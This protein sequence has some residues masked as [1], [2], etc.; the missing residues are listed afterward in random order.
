MR[1]AVD[2]FKSWHASA[3]MVAYT[4]RTSNANKLARIRPLIQ[5]FATENAA[6]MRTTLGY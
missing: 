3:P 1:A 2:L 5:A 4:G 6:F